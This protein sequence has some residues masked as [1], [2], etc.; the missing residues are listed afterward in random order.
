MRHETRDDSHILLGRLNQ[1]LTLEHRPQQPPKI[2][3]I[4]HSAHQPLP[5]IRMDIDPNT[6]KQ[7]AIRHTPILAEPTPSILKIRRRASNS[8][9]RSGPVRSAAK[10]GSSPNWTNSPVRQTVECWLDPKKLNLSG[11]AQMAASW[12]R[13]SASALIPLQGDSRAGGRMISWNRS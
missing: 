9:N 8:P 7:P 11:T 13:E 1:R 5:T 3:H 4:A 2:P 6:Y 12:I 10:E